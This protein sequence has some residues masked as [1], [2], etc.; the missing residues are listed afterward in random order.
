MAEQQIGHRKLRLVPFRALS[1]PQL[2][3]P[4]RCQIMDSRNPP[5]ELCEACQRTEEKSGLQAV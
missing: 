3:F 1:R 4:F 2:T 5:T